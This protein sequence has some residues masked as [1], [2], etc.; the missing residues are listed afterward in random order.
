ML[1]VACYVLVSLDFFVNDTSTTEI[2]T[3]CHTLSL[4]DALPICVGG[5]VQA[6]PATGEPV[7]LVG[8]VALRRLELLLQ[9][10]DEIARYLIEEIVV[11]QAY[12]LQLRRIA[13]A[14]RTMIGDHR[15]TLRKK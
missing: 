13:D 8:L 14:N 5:L 6:R 7:G 2:Y 3:Y 11:D 4:H 15:L 9:M 1:I 12:S 10:I